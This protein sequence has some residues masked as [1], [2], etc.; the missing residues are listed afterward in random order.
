MP[1]VGRKPKP[2]GQKRNRV[3]PTH[4]WIE[5][6]D[7][8]YRGKVP[9]LPKQPRHVVEG[10]PA[11]EPAR[12]LGRMGSALWE[13]AWHSAGALPVDAEALLVVCEQMDERVSLRVKVLRDGDW[14]SRAALRAVDQQVASGLAALGLAAAR[15]IP[16]RWPSET[17]KWWRTVSRMPHCVL[18]NES[19]WQFALDTAMVAAAFHSGDARVANELRQREKIM[20]T[21]ADARR[22]LR[23]RY[24]DEAPPEADPA[25]VTAMD[26]YR[27]TAGGG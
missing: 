9:A 1:M 27:R 15:T 10:P 12:P 17:R 16:A 24:V 18:W 7:K 6:V 22:D 13:R 19:D 21:T 11:P 2:D 4:E 26:A 25:I 23:I 20:G 5:V 3:P 14:R 8:P